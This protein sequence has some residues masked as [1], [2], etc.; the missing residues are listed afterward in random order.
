M[1]RTI[2]LM[3]GLVGCIVFPFC[4]ALMAKAAADQGSYL[5]I[6]VGTASLIAALT[7]IAALMDRS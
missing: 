2:L 6:G 5:L 7:G 3:I 4:F 1:Q